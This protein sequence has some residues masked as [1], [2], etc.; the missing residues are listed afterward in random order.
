MLQRA[1]PRQSRP[2]VMG[3]GGERLTGAL[4][5]QVEV[6]HHLTTPRPETY[7]NFGFPTWGDTPQYAGVLICS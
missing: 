7:L 2:Y 3:S 4:V 6:Q 5:I 1:L